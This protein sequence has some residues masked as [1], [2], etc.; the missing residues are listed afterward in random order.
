MRHERNI[1][2]L[3]L[4]LFATDVAAL[5]LLPVSALGGVPFSISGPGVDPAD[6]QMTTFATGLNFPVGMVELDDGSILVAETNGSRFFGSSSG[7]L[8]RYADTD[9]DGVA[10]SRSVLVSNVPG[11]G[12]TALRRAGDLFFTTGQGRGKPISIYR[13]G[14]TPAAPLSLEGTINL[15]YPSGGWLHPHSA[16][17]VRQTPGVRDNYDL[18]FQ[19][20]SKVNFAATTATVSLTS[21]IGV[22]GTLNGDALHLVTITDHGN[23]VSASSVQQI[24]TGLRNP[25]GVA[26]QPSTGDLY[27]QDNGI[28]GLSDPNE[29]LSADELNRIPAADVGGASEN[30]G[31]PNNYIE[32]RTGNIIGGQG[33]EPLV[34]FQPIPA[35]NGAESEGPNDIVFAPPRFPAALRDGMFV[36]MHG[37]FSLGGLSNEENP[38]VFTDLTDHSYFHFIEN[39]EP[40]IGHLDG[41]LST[42]D[43][44]FI[45]DISPTGGFSSGAANRGVIY[46][47]RSLLPAV[48]TGDMDGNGNVDFDDIEA[49]V[50]GLNDPAGYEARFGVRP[51]LKGDTDSNGQF[52]F[53][54]IPGFVDLL[55]GASASQTVPEPS[56]LVLVVLGLLTMAGYRRR[57]V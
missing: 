24:A 8:V 25:A 51:S 9:A 26:F 15:N 4:I 42:E 28:D 17:G 6:F 39:D 16:L 38:L 46:R 12:L 13:A 27:L 47:I 49:F 21:N 36:G 5:G 52:D 56:A 40:S 7:S 35:P 53:D 2:R 31:F 19:L 3:L 14:A 37:K 29:P 55:N 43:S 50:L 1:E 57:A 10:D 32:Y 33:I 11:G 48:I 30:F 22:T 34:A 23:S 45:A 20:G 44:L 41:L 18:I 54:D